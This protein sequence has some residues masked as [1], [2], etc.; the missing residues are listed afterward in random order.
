[1]SLPGFRKNEQ[2]A[3]ILFLHDAFGVI[4]SIINFFF[5]GK[6]CLVVGSGGEGGACAPFAPPPWVRGGG[7]CAP[8]APPPLGSGTATK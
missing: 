1:M 8:F 2:L 7:A 6:V 3:L 5:W 4:R